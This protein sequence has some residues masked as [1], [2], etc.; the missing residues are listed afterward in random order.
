MLKVER[1][2][3]SASAHVTCARWP[4]GRRGCGPE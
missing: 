4:F 2:A 1:L 3:L